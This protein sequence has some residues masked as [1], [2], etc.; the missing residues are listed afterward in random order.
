LPAISIIVPIYNVESYLRKCIDSILN[1][2]FEDF[3]V[4][5][6]NDGSTDKSGSI[7][8]EYAGMHKDKVRVIHKQ[9][10]EGAGAPR[11]AGIEA[12]QGQYLLFVDGDDY[13]APNTIDK[14]YKAILLHDVDIVVF[15]MNIITEKGEFIKTYMD[16]RPYNVVL[17]AKDRPDMLL[18][19]ASSWNKLYKRKLFVQK[20]IRFP[21]KVWYDDVATIPKLCTAAE[22]IVFIN[23]A[24]YHY[25]V[26]YNSITRNSNILRM[27][28]ILT[29]L[30][31]LVSYYKEKDLFELYKSEIEF[32]AI[33]NLYIRVP[34]Y[35]LTAPKGDSMN[36]LINSVNEFLAKQFPNH[37]SNKYLSN[38]HKTC[39]PKF[40]AMETIYTN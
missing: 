38:L 4:I 36:K 17:N 32:V 39:I 15:G 23:E 28:D 2:T 3:E 19:D 31:N 34:D 14:T 35:I 11:N 16:K 10:S 18:I 8:D 1:Q 9:N 30:D 33:Y 5:L 37:K 27:L 40:K 26:R 12:S 13:I 20:G 29:V 22:S 25:L 24:F 21:E 6:V 7:C